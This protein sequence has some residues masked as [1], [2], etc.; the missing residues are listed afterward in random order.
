VAVAA[1]P[2]EWFFF[3]VYDI[4]RPFS[5]Q[6]YTGFSPNRTFSRKLKIS[7]QSAA[8]QNRSGIQGKFDP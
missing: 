6:L 2:A 7:T 1:P 4:A 8:W 5:D 3:Q